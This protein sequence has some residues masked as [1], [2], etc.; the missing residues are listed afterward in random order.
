MLFIFDKIN[1]DILINNKRQWLNM[2]L[3]KNKNVKLIL[4]YMEN[5]F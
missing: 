2:N 3:N 1:Y 5:I 4:L